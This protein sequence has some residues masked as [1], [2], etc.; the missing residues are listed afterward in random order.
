M[1][2]YQGAAGRGG[3]PYGEQASFMLMKAVGE[4]E[5]ATEPDTMEPNAE[6]PT[7]EP[8]EPEPTVVEAIT[9][10]PPEEPEEAPSE[11]AVEEAAPEPEPVTEEEAPEPE[12]VVE[13][14]PA[15]AEEEP[16][17]PEPEDLGVTFTFNPETPFL[18][19]GT[20]PTIVNAQV[21]GIVE[22]A[23]EKFYVNVVRKGDNGIT[24]H[25]ADAPLRPEGARTATSHSWASNLPTF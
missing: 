22:P 5:A 21:N 1:R 10:A 20:K 12:P 4:A 3:S 13:E 19:D 18:T 16:L 9:E 17:P 6:I 25:V 15:P 24:I 14:E 23:S 11:E 2:I 7:D 8:T